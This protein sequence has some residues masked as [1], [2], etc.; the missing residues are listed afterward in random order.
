V[1]YPISGDRIG[2]AFSGT[3]TYPEVLQLTQAL[4][5][6]WNRGLEV[7]DAL[8]PK[9]A[10]EPDRMMDLSVAQ[11]LGIQF[12][13]S[14][15]I[16]RFYDL[17]EKLLYGP[18]KTSSETLHSLREIVEEEISNGMTLSALCE[19]NPFLGFHS[20]AEAYKYFPAKLQWR[21]DRLRAMLDTEFVE[22]ER[23]V[24]AGEVVFPALS[25]LNDDTLAYSCAPAPEN[26]E[27]TWREDAAWEALA[28]ADA[29]LTPGEP[30][31]SWRAVRDADALYVRVQ[32]VQPDGAASMSAS[33]HVQSAHIYPRRTF[34]L[35]DKG[36]RNTQLAWH[37]FNDQWEIDT[38][39]TNGIRTFRFR[40][41]FTAFNGEFDET[42]FPARPMRINVQLRPG[43]AGAASHTWAPA[44]PRPPMNRLGYGT[45]DPTEMGWLRFVP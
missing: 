4:S 38:T 11:A 18:V 31:A 39:T 30:A 14:Y 12:R 29:P 22:A 10:N 3:H 17:R 20:E 5:E 27:E 1:D 6:T 44:S 25:G 24:A 34:E 21:A 8:Q 40:I 37:A 32:S 35:D 33:V 28:L 19:S 26:F 16:L 9:Y 7:L 13:S 23:A 45:E 43:S 41:P 36:T 42:N 2:E 15:N